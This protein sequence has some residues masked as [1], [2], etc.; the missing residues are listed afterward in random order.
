LSFIVFF[1]EPGQLLLGLGVLGFVAFALKRVLGAV[2]RKPMPMQEAAQLIGAE[3]NP[4]DPGQMAGQPRCR[5]GRKPVAQR[6]RAGL[7]RLFHCLDEGRGRATGAT[8]RMAGRQRFDASPAV[9]PTDAYDRVGATAESLSNRRNGIA[10]VG[11][12]NNQAVAKDI[13]RIGGQ[14]HAIQF[15]PLGFAQCNTPSHG[16]DLHMA[17]LP[18]GRSTM[19]T[20]FNESFCVAT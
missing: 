9:Q 18:P 16:Y 20:V 11:H 15:V 19:T 2:D 7:H 17:L 1:F 4:R 3:S 6:Q 8:G 14:S 12:Q 13:G 10:R 5:P